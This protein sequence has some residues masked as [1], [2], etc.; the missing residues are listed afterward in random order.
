MILSE[1]DKRE[2]LADAA[3]R[4]RREDFA[5]GRKLALD[6]GPKTLNEY[7]QFLQDNQRFFPSKNFA[8]KTNT[9]LNKL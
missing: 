3:S 8:R 1:Q 6:K 7:I 2:M 9:K 5:A 4:L